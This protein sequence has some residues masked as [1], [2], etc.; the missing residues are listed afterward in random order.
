[1]TRIM[2]MRGNAKRKGWKPE[3]GKW[4]PKDDSMTPAQRKATRQR[5]KAERIKSSEKFKQILFSE[6]GQQ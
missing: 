4:N 6:E 1:M 2:R 3:A 5:R